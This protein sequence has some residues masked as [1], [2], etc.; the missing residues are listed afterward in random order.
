MDTDNRHKELAK[1][2]T[3]KNY[4]VASGKMPTI[5]YNIL[6]EQMVFWKSEYGI[7]R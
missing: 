3:L 7:P 5:V 1:Q 2:Y 4:S 6:D